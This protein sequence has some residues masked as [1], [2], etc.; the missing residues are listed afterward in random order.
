MSARLFPDVSQL[1][2][3][4]LTA[5]VGLLCI[6]LGGWTGTRRAEI[7][8]IAG[9]GVAALASLVF[10][11]LTEIPLSAI[12]A[13]L[14]VAGAAGLLRWSL[15]RDRAEAASLGRVSLLALPLIAGSA[16]AVPIAW[17]DFSHWLPN[18]TYICINNHFPTA[19]LPAISHHAGY[20]YAMALPGLA[21]FLLTGT[22]PESA[23]IFWNL[24]VM[25]CA[26]AAFS[27][28]L[29]RR[30]SGVWPSYPRLLPWISAAAGLLL[31]GLASPTFVPK[32]F[33]SNM[34]DAATASVL[35]VLGALLFEW[36]ETGGTLRKQIAVAVPFGFCCV[37]FIDLRQVNAVLFVLLLAGVVLAWWRARRWPAAGE[38]VCLAIVL[39][40]SATAFLLWKRYTDAQIPGGAFVFMPFSGWRWAVMPRTV[41]NMLHVMSGKPG[42]F[43]L[44]IYLAISVVLIRRVADWP[45]RLLVTAAAT[46]SVGMIGF[47]GFTY[48]AADFN[49]QEAAAAAAFWRYMTEVGSLVVLAAISIVPLRWLGRLPALRVSAALLLIVLVVPF[50][51][52]PLYRA[53]LSSPV[54]QMRRANIALDAAVPRDQPLLLMDERD[55]GF[56]VM[57]AYYDLMISQRAAAEA[58]RVV[59]TWSDPNG[60]PAA[61][62]MARRFDEPYVW[63][64]Q[65]APAMSALVGT[66]MRRDTAYLLRQTDGHLK[67]EAQWQIAA[68]PG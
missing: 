34:G 28:L 31:A 42:L 1:L 3:L 50:A 53:D 7:A 36:A 9:W 68:P 25:L 11:T 62:V 18:L 47:L 59:A 2:A 60:I 54:P 13:V 26:S 43:L 19:A 23:A 64:A 39:A 8:L 40:L 44:I 58:P 15:D 57:L 48:L 16:G 56:G 46:V 21:V 37:A 38:V 61:A 24:I 14:G 6:G 12:A 27:R 49:E 55:N 67:V 35:A 4:L 22:V 30:L 20:P 51:A 65:G 29:A 63:L 33:F 32:I 41:G 52:I 45:T 66:P 5:L 17:D 10:G